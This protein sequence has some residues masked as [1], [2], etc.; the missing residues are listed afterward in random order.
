VLDALHAG[1]NSLAVAETFT[2]GAI[3]TRLLQVEG[4][5]AVFRRGV[6]SR[7]LGQLA[8][9]VGLRAETIAPAMASTLASALRV[10]SG[11]SHALA[12]VVTMEAGGDGVEAGGSISIGVADATGGCAVR[13]ARLVGGREWV[14]L[15]AAEMGLDCL[16]RH[17][18]GLPTDERLDFERR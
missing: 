17:L 18:L 11:A 2:G 7:D 16:R 15:G 6:V 5:D 3:A 13:E 1:S 8:A 9:V 10:Q 4:A 14:R 12:V